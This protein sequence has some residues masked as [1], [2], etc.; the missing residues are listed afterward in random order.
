MDVLNTLY[1][2][3]GLSFEL[4]NITYTE[5]EEWFDYVDNEERYPQYDMKEALRQGDRSALNVY[6]VGFTFAN[7]EGVLG[8]ATFPWLEKED[9]INDGVV[10]S[11]S[12]LPGGDLEKFNTGKVR[13]SFHREIAMR[14]TI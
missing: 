6:T 5:D 7:N 13:S 2:G 1:S 8:Y 9:P 14:L 10:L 11:Y 3:T 4:R 12:T